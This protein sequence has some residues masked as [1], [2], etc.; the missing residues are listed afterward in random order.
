MSERGHQD[1]PAVGL[2]PTEAQNPRWVLPLLV[3]LYAGLTLLLVVRVPLGAA[4]DESQHMLYVQHLADRGKLPVFQP[5]GA[6]HP[7]YEF[8][9]PPLYYAVCAPLWKATGAGVQNYLC[10]LVSLLCGA[11]T[12]VFLWRA[13]V[14]LF[15]DDRALPVLATGF[16]ALWP[17]HQGVGASAGNDA[18][19]GLISA[20]IFFVIARGAARR[21]RV[22]DSIML[23]VLV[24][25]GLLTKM[26]CLVLT[27][28]AA[29]AAWSLSRQHSES[30][31]KSKPP[32]FA[33]ATVIAVALAISGWW[34]VRNQQLYGDPFGIKIFNQAFGNNPSALLAKAA[35]VGYVPLTTYLGAL[36]FLL[37][38]TTW[39]IFGGPETAR[40]MMNPFNG[41]IHPE[42]MPALAPM[43]VCAAATV[44]A[45]WGLLSWHETRATLAPRTRTALGWWMIGFILVALAWAQF[46][47]SYFQAQARYFHAALLPICVG[48]ALGW[49]H[50]LGSASQGRGLWISAVLFGLTLLALSLWN[51]WGWRTLV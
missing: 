26:T 27:V 10:R 51:A 2:H 49:R 4:P 5:L 30:G 34:F 41:K 48:C 39:G 3:S 28:V 18:L 11:V 32:I 7:G 20:A 36:W 46:N 8:H 24:G 9:Q 21:W 50:A 47:L 16:L 1:A 31:E 37:F 22:G 19:A 35:L 6:P 42:A 15:P 45:A 12:L 40:A 33:A 29:G 13:V 23:G 25:L 44:L 43:A 38:C 14:A 17:L